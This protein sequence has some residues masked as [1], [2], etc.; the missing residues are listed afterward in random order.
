MPFSN[1][2]DPELW[3]AIQLDDKIAF[4]MLFDRYW[5]RLYKTGFKLTRDHEVSREI[6]H[7]IFINIWDRR[8]TL[9]IGSVPSYLLTAVRYQYYNRARAARSPLVFTTDYNLL[10][11]ATTLNEA[12]LRSSEQDMVITLKELLVSLPKRCQEIFLMSRIDSLTN[13]EIAVKLNIS[14]RTV[15]NQ[16][17]HALKHIRNSMHNYNLS[18][19]LIL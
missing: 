14:K 12:E 15:E 9:S 2:T 6:V 1:L 4:R 7:D 10:D 3:S 8:H 18:F 5:A 16:I 19:F 17:T 13:D 11:H